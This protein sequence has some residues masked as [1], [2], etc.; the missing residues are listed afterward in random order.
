MSGSTFWQIKPAVPVRPIIS[1]MNA[2]REENLQLVGKLVGE[3]QDINA[4]SRSKRV[5]AIMLAAEQGLTNVVNL[6]FQRGADIELKDWEG[7]TPLI[8]A[9]K[10]GKTETVNCLCALKADV[11]SVD[12]QG[13]TAVA[14]AASN[15]HAVVLQQLLELNGDI[16]LTDFTTD[17]KTVFFPFWGFRGLLVNST[18]VCIPSL[19][20]SNVA[21][22]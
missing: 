9:S 16:A 20:S 13:R 12:T 6:L 8:L 11:Q 22:E 5:T 21:F 19:A 17:W 4:I 15:G 1:L 10:N 14:W 3:V 18:H 7:F 2:I